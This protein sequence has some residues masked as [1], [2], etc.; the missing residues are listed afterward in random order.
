MMKPICVT[1][2]S[3]RVHIRPVTCTPFELGS[4]LSSLFSTLGD[5]RTVTYSER[6]LFC[7]YQTTINVGCKERVVKGTSLIEKFYNMSL[8]SPQKRMETLYLNT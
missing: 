2:M 5:F 4:L 6:N 8:V 7:C 3:G 1:R